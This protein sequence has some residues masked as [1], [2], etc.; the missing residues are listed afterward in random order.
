MEVALQQLP[1]DLATCHQ[2]IAQLMETLHSKDQQLDQLQHRLQQLLRARFGPRAEKVDPAQLAL[3]AREI[4]AEARG[5]QEP[6]P[7]PVEESAPVRKGH[8]RRKLPGNL[9]RQR[10]VID[11]PAEERIC[12]CCGKEMAKIGEDT[13]ERIDYIPASVYVIE[14]VRPKYACKHCPDGTVVTAD[15]PR[16]PIEKG[17][18]GPGMLAYIITSKFAD[19]QPLHRLC[20]ILH[21]HGLEL[22]PST[23]GGWMGPSAKLATPLL[24]LMIDRV[25][26]SRVIH[27]DDTPM[28]VLDKDRPS[29]RQGRLWTYRGD[30]LHPYTV[31]DYTPSRKRDGP[32]QFLGDYQG[33][34]QADAYGGYDGIYANGKV[35]EVLCWAHARRKVFDA[36]DSDSARATTALAYIRR[37]YQIER[38]AKEQFYKQSQRDDA[39]SLAAI[40]LELRQKQSL[41]VLR[42]FEGWMR[43][44]TAGEAPVLPK[45][46]MGAA[47]NYILGNWA[48]LLRYAEDGDL[49]I[50]NNVSE[51][52]LRGA[53]LGRRNYTFFGSDN[54]GHTAAVLYSLIASAKRHGLDPFAYLRDVL[55]RISDHPANRL[56][57]LLPDH[58]KLRPIP[59][60]NP[61]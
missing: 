23:V 24:E 15:K 20:Q 35:I 41:P 58:W 17:L 8:G 5:A 46:P 16:Q 47:I 25:L 4:L 32:E 33:Y 42:E 31:Y 13:S 59:P 19:H 50:D 7:L 54:G 53:A 30:D 44:Q 21:R 10:V 14:Q 2:L 9:P 49:D 51:R 3:F 56:E 37:L 61:A 55:A 27:T 40:R 28:P 1:H 57:E 29:T 43:Q 60:A 22:S 6:A 36:T 11:V 48:A 34:L 52:D 26:D 38:Q 18:P 12:K 45:S 39:R